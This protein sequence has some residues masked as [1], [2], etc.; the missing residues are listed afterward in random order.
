MASGMHSVP[1][2]AM[3]SA[4]E[5][6]TTCLGFHFQPANC[7]VGKY[8]DHAAVPTQ[9]QIVTGSPN[10]C[11]MILTSCWSNRLTAPGPRCP[12]I[13]TNSR[14]VELFVEPGQAWVPS[15]NNSQPSGLVVPDS[16]SRLGRIGPGLPSPTG[17]KIARKWGTFGVRT[18][19]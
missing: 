8:A 7:H 13:R 18:A 17:P 10:P 12:T 19:Q 4:K 16:G 1:A 6:P 11:P 2:A 3:R 15:P 9:Q 5:P 14:E